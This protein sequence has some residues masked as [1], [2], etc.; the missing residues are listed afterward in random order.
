MVSGE[1]PA[2]AYP[3]FTACPERSPAM[4]LGR[5][6]AMGINEN[7]VRNIIVATLANHPACGCCEQVRAAWQ[8][9]YDMRNYASTRYDPTELAIA[10]HYLY[11]RS[12]VCSAEVSLKQMKLLVYGYDQVKRLGEGNS[13]VRKLIQSNTEIPPSSPT[14]E[15]RKWGYLGADDGES[16]RLRCNASKTP[17]FIARVK[18]LENKLRSYR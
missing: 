3:G 15:A 12:R 17:P 2:T 18:F 4:T 1:I 9:L 16:D 8:E 11:A 14:D 5:E 7:N 6:G 13:V 10:E